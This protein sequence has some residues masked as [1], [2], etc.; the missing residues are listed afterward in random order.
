M[1]T[2]KN[3]SK[4]YGQTVALHPTNL[5]LAPGRTTVF[6]GPSGCGKSTLLRLMI[7]LVRPTTGTVLFQGTP[8]TPENVRPLRH[9]MGYVIQEGGLFPHLTARE[10]VTLLAR[11]LGRDAAWID[12]RV[13][14]LADLVHLPLDRLDA[15]PERL[16]GGQRQRVG[17]MR[18]LLL[19]PD[20]LLLDEPLGALDPMIRAGLQDDLRA[21]FRQL[22]K[23]V[24]LVTHDLAEAA[25]F[26]DTVVLLRAG[27]IVQQ[28][29]FRDLVEAPAEPF[30]EAF[31]NAQRTLHLAP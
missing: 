17:L 2:L 30:V 18:A 29:P 25:F 24:V 20:V 22:E 7:G 14:T 15:Y 12:R 31:V 11:H 10:N 4:R 26:G 3:V 16:S 13:R 9:R 28:G 19:D 5:T 8:L 21:I 27:R 6:I 1:L 23:T